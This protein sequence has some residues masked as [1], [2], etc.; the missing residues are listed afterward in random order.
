M[1]WL[2]PCTLYANAAAPLSVYYAT[3]LLY[4]VQTPSP[5]IPLAPIVCAPRNQAPLHLMWLVPCIL[6][7]NA[8]APFLVAAAMG[9]DT[10]KYTF[11]QITADTFTFCIE[12][13]SN[14]T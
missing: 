14:K 12:I 11:I 7:V 5:C 4:E 3:Q 9:Y 1:M 8:A 6:Y 13:H 10:S 2:V